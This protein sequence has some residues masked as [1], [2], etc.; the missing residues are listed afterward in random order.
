V[1]TYAGHPFVGKLVSI[2]SKVD[3][4]SRNVQ[5]R[6]SFAN[7]D[8]RLVPGMYATVEIDN[9]AATNEIT[10]PQSSI[11]YNPYG[12]TVYLVHK[13]EGDKGTAALT[14]VQRF[15]QLGDTRGDQVAVKS[16]IK[17]GDEVVT[18][19]QVKLRNGAPIVVN[20]SVVPT[21]DANPTPPNE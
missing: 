6:A 16:G 19:G 12:D 15:V 11:T 10:L 7:A 2:N 13:T 8:R 1:D 3:A 21:N 9:A 4:S 20:N 17:V 5:A 18:A 14:A